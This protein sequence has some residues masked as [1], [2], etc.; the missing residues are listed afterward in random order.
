MK[1]QG[2]LSNI[3]KFLHTVTVSLIGTK[4]GLDVNLVG[5]DSV[6]QSNQIGQARPAN[7]TA[8]SVINPN[9]GE[10]IRVNMLLVANVSASGLTFRL[11][12]D[13]SGT[14]F[15]ETTALFFDSDLRANES[16][17]IRFDPAIRL[18][19][20]SENLAVRSSSGNNLNFIFYGETTT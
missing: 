6:A 14:T 9:A 3:V 12:H 5:D 2:N 1:L 8:V 13:P 15:D 17:M 11:F 10:V 19:S 7:T 18:S 20:T 4:V 16:H